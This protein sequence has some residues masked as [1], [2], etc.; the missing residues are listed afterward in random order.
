MSS[1]AIER[2]IEE[3]TRMM[4]AAAASDDFEKAAWLR[5]E[6]AALK[7]PQ[8]RMAPPGAMGLGTNVPVPERP[9]NW[10]PPRKP[11]PMTTN[12]KPRGKR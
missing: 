5:D 11:D 6:I 3:L 1:A 12:V 10:R 2:K 8:V 7:D 9:K 4:A